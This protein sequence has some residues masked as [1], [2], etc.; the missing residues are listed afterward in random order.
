[1]WW[2]NYKSSGSASE[3]R[4]V[5]ATRRPCYALFMK[6]ETRLILVLLLNLVMVAGLVIVGLASHS[7]GVLAAGGDYIADSTAIGLGIL[8][9]RIQQHPNGYTKATTVVA[10]INALFLLIVTVF[11]VATATQRLLG[12]TPD[13]AAQPVVIVSVLATIAMLIGAFVLDDDDDKDDLHMRSV[14]LD[15]ISDAAASAAVAVT[16]A[17][18]LAT[19]R[20]Y[21]LDSLA[22]LLIGLFIGYHAIKL[23]RDVIRDL[24]RGA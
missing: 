7:L 1:V 21:W 13:I 14:I 20:L 23:L 8:A 18:I 2:G 15:T 24:R 19:G 6:Q 9:I 11:V 5:T 12:N 3:A 17:I 22:A 4:W 10:L 16:G